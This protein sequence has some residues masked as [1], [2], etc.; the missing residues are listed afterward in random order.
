MS[1]REGTKV[2]GNRI[3]VLM[4]SLALIMLG[5][6]SIKQGDTIK[7]MKDTDI[8]VLQHIEKLHESNANVLLNNI[9]QYNMLGILERDIKSHQI[10][11]DNIGR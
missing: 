4:L 1:T 8:Y 10:Q 3:I 5:I 6:V 7:E 9:K 2:S 11:L